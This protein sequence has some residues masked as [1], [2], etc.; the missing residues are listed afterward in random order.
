MAETTFQ[1]EVDR[2]AETPEQS[3]RIMFLSN[4]LAKFLDNHKVTT[5]ESVCLFSEFLK[6]IIE[7]QEDRRLAKWKEDQKKKNEERG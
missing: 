7:E 2:G 5:N 4:K 6:M 3:E 1:I